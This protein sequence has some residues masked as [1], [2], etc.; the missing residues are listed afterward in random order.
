MRQ[1]NIFLVGPMGTGK[2]AVGAALAARLGRPFHDTDAL[3]VSA[4]G[5]DIPALFQTEGEV[6]FRLREAAIVRELAAAAGIVG[7]TGGGCVLLE[8]NRRLLKDGNL[9]V[10][11]RAGLDNR[12]ARI[13]DAED[14][15]LLPGGDLRAARKLLDDEREP[16]YLEV[17]DCTVNNDGTVEAAVDAVVRAAGL[18]PPR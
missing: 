1:R 14:R 3:V 5:L 9:V 16:L 17:A 12:V 4:A 18:Q 8:E 6:R 10:Y 11:L 2:T 15:P 13:G 7:A